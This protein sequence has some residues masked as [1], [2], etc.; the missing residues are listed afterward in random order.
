MLAYDLGVGSGSGV[1]YALSADSHL[2]VHFDL[3][4]CTKWIHF[5]DNMSNSNDLGFWRFLPLKYVA[6]FY[7]R[8]R[9]LV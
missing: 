5:A 4:I 3:W 2:G 1:G 9:R 7:T 8:C 6:S